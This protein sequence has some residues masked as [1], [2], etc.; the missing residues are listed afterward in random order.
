MIDVVYIKYVE[1][2]YNIVTD[3]ELVFDN[4]FFIDKFYN[5]NNFVKNEL[6]FCQDWPKRI[7]Q[8]NKYIIILDGE[9]ATQNIRYIE[10]SKNII[11]DLQKNKCRIFVTI[12]EGGVNDDGYTYF[13]F[14]KKDYAP[15]ELEYIVKENKIP[16]DNFIWMSPEILIDKEHYNERGMGLS[17]THKFF[18]LWLLKLD[19]VSRSHYYPHMMNLFKRGTNFSRI[20]YFYT[21]NSSPRPHRFELLN[22]LKNNDLL[23]Y[24]NANFFSNAHGE[25]STDDYHPDWRDVEMVGSKDLKWNYEYYW[26][27]AQLNNNI[28]YLPTYAINIIQS[29]NSYFQIIT[30]S[31][32]DY[33]KDCKYPYIF[34]NEKIWKSMITLQPFI[35]MSQPNVLRMLKEFG[36]KTFH[37]YIDESYDSVLD[38]DERKNLIFK[39]IKRLCSMTR[40]EI[41]RWFWNMKDILIHNHNRLS[42]YSD[43]HCADFIEL[44]KKNIN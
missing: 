27:G 2:E 38:N 31:I 22:F 15:G 7:L 16:R 28:S 17:F 36:F 13:D 30:T 5:I 12:R 40:D 10:S 18:N 33:D 6:H 20:K 24:G 39:E 26:K 29:F 21:V 25:T 34:F 19:S 4:S 11:S 8:K 42:E 3:T 37:P 1:G 43:E 23:K 44:L 32:Y 35:I 14:E 9:D 41:H